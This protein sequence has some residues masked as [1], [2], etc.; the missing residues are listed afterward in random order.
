MSKNLPVVVPEKAHADLG[1]SVAHRWMPCPGSIRMASQVPAPPSN[2]FAD[3][4]T[5]AHA[6]GELCLRHKVDPSMYVDT[7]LE[8]FVV[9]E[10]MAEAVKVYTDYCRG[11]MET[12]S[13]FFIE[14]KFNLSQLRPPGPMYGTSDFAAYAKIERV[15]EVVDLKFGRGVLV[16]VKDNPQLLYYALGVVL[17]LGPGYDIDEVRITVVQPRAAHPDGMIRTHTVSYEDLMAFAIELVERAKL[18]TRA[19]AP[20]VPG[21]HCRFC[22]AAGGACPAEAGRALELA[23][24]EFDVVSEKLATPPD[25][26]SLPEE[27][28]LRI[29]A[30]LPSIEAFVKGVRMRA[31]ARLE[32][33]EAVPG[34][35][36]VAKRAIRK[37]VDEDNT[38]E[39]LRALPAG[40]TDED[41]LVMKLKSPAQIGKLIGDKN[42][43]AEQVIKAS[44]GYTMVPATDARPE[45]IPT[46]GEEFSAITAGDD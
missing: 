25:A 27:T 14:R 1:A 3:E 17:E 13:E 30:H 39:W 41:I 19:D 16:E 18:T 35:K 45:V 5:A 33:G 31:L 32:R 8:K 36:L 20:L 7:T 42:L 26:E 9:D 29:L 4:G 44:S 40:L 34:V 6:L 28:F 22:P 23:Q 11:L 43:P 24:S 15:L 37:W 46:P 38:R 10:A 2:F 12:A 21:S